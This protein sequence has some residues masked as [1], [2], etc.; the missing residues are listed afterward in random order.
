MVDTVERSETVVMMV[1]MMMNNI[2]I[3]IIL[4]ILTILTIMTKRRVSPQGGEAVVSG[5]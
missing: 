3:L 2:I 1:G 4:I 5:N